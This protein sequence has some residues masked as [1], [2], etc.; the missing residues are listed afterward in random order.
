MINERKPQEF[1]RFHSK[2]E[3][4][5]NG[6]IVCNLE[7]QWRK[8]DNER[9]CKIEIS[10]L[11]V[12]LS[13]YEARIHLYIHYNGKDP[14]DRITLNFGVKVGSL[15]ECLEHLDDYLQHICLDHDRNP[16]R[17]KCVFFTKNEKNEIEELS[18]H[19]FTFEAKYDC[20]AKEISLIHGWDLL[21][22]LNRCY[23]ETQGYSTKGALDQYWNYGTAVGA[24]SFSF[25]LN[26]KRHLKSGSGTEDRL[27]IVVYEE[28][29]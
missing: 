10:V 11:K 28:T 1:K 19:S 25:H 15:K 27:L 14:N 24:H 7:H 18:E 23:Y 26:G 22:K 2:W 5:S 3:E 29:V 13:V 17:Y 4:N 8:E 21:S 9:L 12:S 16:K 20:I 6:K